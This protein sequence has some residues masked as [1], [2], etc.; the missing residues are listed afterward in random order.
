MRFSETEI[1]HIAIALF[2]ITL[3]LTFHF[4]LPLA[5]GFV[6]ILLTFGIAFI[7]HELAHKYVAQSYGFWAEFRYWETGLILGLLMAFTPILFLAPGAVYISSGFNGITKKQNAYI[8][9]AGATTNVAIA[10]LFTIFSGF[11]GQTISRFAVDI[12]LLLAV[13]NLL[14]VPPLDG[15]KVFAWSPRNWIFIFLGLIAIRELL[16]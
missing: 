3:A 11:S 4:N 9:L 6:I 10:F 14:P 1:K 15:S 12:N 16:T 7:A 13:F 8:S 5:R 2:V